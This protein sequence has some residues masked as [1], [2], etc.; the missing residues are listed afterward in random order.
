VA[1]IGT[2]NDLSLIP[3]DQIY[4][5]TP[6]GT[7]ALT[8]NTI[9]WIGLSSIDG[10]IAQWDYEADDSGLYVSGYGYYDNTD[11]YLDNSTGAYLMTV[12]DTGFGDEFD[13]INPLYGGG[14]VIDSSGI[15]L[16]PLYASWET[17]GAPG[18][19]SSV[20]VELY[21]PAP[22]PEPSSAVLIGV[23]LVGLLAWRLRSPAV[24]RALAAVLPLAAGLGLWVPAW[25]QTPAAVHRVSDDEVS[26]TLKYWTK[27]RMASAIPAP[28]PA[29][30]GRAPS[31]RLARPEDST[32]LVPGFDPAGA[33]LN[34]TRSGALRPHTPVIPPATGNCSDCTNNQTCAPYNSTFTVTDSYYQTAQ[35]NLPYV[36][37]GKVYFT[38]SGQNY[39]CSGASIGGSA[40]L[41]AGHCV[42]DGVGNFHTN[43]T[44][45]P[46]LY[47]ADAPGYPTASPEG[48][49][50][51]A[52][53][54]ITF[55]E[56]FSGADLGRDVGFAIVK[57]YPWGS[58]LT[59]PISAS[60]SQVNGYLGF[61]WNQN[62]TGALWNSF[63]Y[64]INFP[65]N[66]TYLGSLYIGTG[67]VMIQTNAVTACRDSSWS[68]ATVGI[69]SL[70]GNG[71]SG[72][73]WV[74]NFLPTLADFNL[75]YAG[76][77][78]SY[79]YG[80]GSEV[81]GVATFIPTQAYSPYFDQAVKDLKDQAVA[82]K[83]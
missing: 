72:G 17:A 75:N 9:Y 27:E 74:L 35:A 50:W 61:A 48:Y 4:T 3:G 20:S 42:A 79:V 18:D 36:A 13:S 78:N 77:V 33:P 28:L 51:A 37:V 68:P 64:P 2:L 8:G 22:A 44:F 73:P 6:V 62:P 19:L 45:I 5:F 21:D 15:A 81:S 71:A 31:T 38:M 49:V 23:G 12:I 56:F 66:G 83:P 53:Q 39:L 47:V 11:G 7:I 67:L 55:P 82:T 25:A 10:S 70:M 16:G 43:W 65:Y 76:G 52:T 60:L 54:L 24:R 41:T 46:D 58:S 1:Y 34:A 30:T 32:S 63:G 80:Y 59:T 26:A 29:V 69:G 14:T 57:G 40:V